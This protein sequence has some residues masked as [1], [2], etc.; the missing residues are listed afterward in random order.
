MNPSNALTAEDI[1]R[2]ILERKPAAGLFAGMDWRLA[3]LPFRLDPSMANEFERLG[4]ILLQFHRAANLLYRLS[5]QNK[6]PE[7]IARW[8]DQGK[9]SDLIAWQRDPA[10]K[11][12]IPRVF[13]PDVLLTEDGLRI[14][15]LDSVPGG[16]GLTAW[17]N[18]TYS[19]ILPA[20]GQ[21]LTAPNLPG[22]SQAPPSLSV[23][24]RQV[25]GGANDMQTGFDSIFSQ[26][27]RVHIVVSEEASAYRPEMEWLAHELGPDRFQVRDTQYVEFAP[28]DAVYRFFELFDLPQV[29]SANR[30]FNAA[31]SKHILLTPP[32]KPLFEE[33]MW[34]ALLWNRNLRD[35]WRQELGESFFHQ[36]LSW[37]PYTWILDPASLPPHA[38]IPELNLTD[39]R[40]LCQLSQRQR[41]LI[42]KI[43]GY[44]PL[45]WGARGV[46]L[47]SDLSQ[48]DWSEAVEHALRSFPQS[49]YVLQ[50]YHKPK[51]VSADW[52]DP[53]SRRVY[54]LDG[55]VRL[56]P[57]YFVS[58]QQ[59]AARSK[60]CGV[61]ATIC[62]SDRK[63]VHGMRD[64]ILAPCMI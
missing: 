4:R 26:A 25:I 50:R 54:S 38:A 46:H 42:L 51:L 12:D 5:W 57:Y 11:N 6:Q 28:G 2:L 44:S 45:A 34:L 15:E 43:S 37:T 41:D 9:S 16:I 31:K 22:N 48:A 17:L 39:W 64:A 52:F 36:L 56:C 59:D 61:L 13:R 7:W 23:V 1:A 40:Q 20:A 62:P 10:F 14:T 29:A 49:P 3:L 63:I 33:K 30:L 24:G 47:G 53:G 8:L 19:E 27:S 55:R 18:Q 21:A 60:L 58:G 35:F 32:F